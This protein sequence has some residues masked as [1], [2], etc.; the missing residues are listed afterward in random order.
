MGRGRQR[1]LK[2]VRQGKCSTA[3]RCRDKTFTAVLPKSHQYPG[4]ASLPSF[5]CV[6]LLSVVFVHDLEFVVKYAQ[7]FIFNDHPMCCD[8]GTTSTPSLL[9]S[10]GCAAVRSAC[11]SSIVSDRLRCTG[12]CHTCATPRPFAK[13]ISPVG[14]LQCVL[15]KCS[16]NSLPSLKPP[17]RAD[18]GLLAQRFGCD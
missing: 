15:S 2:F 13:R 11:C 7:H 18:I 5:I 16:L 9:L 10:N 17:R 6:P 12:R 14:N 1:K 3:K 4:G 8:P